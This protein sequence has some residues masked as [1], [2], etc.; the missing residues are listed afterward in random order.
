MGV[1]VGFGI[2][3]GPVPPPPLPHA[4]RANAATTDAMSLFI[5]AILHLLGRRA[6]ETEPNANRSFTAF[7]WAGRA[8]EVAGEAKGPVSDAQTAAIDR[9]RE[10]MNALKVR[11]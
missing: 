5:A 10:R 6:E 8:S 7:S 1:G 3:P 4:V 2:G 9:A 11:L